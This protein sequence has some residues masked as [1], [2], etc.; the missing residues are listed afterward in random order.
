MTLEHRL[1]YDYHPL[2]SVSAED[3]TKNVTED[4]Q[5]NCDYMEISAGA[6]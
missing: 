6:F 1:D 2:K 5:L 3:A 4:R